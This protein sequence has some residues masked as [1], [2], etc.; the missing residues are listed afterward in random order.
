M[1]D[2]VLVMIAFFCLFVSSK[3]VANAVQRSDYLYLGFILL[4]FPFFAFGILAL[5]YVSGI[6]PLLFDW[7]S[8]DSPFVPMRVL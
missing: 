7:Q 3:L 6:A 1:M 2:A 5:L 8:P 4:A